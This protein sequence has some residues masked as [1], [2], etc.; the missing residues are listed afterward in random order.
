M[1]NRKWKTGKPDSVWKTCQRLGRQG[2]RGIG[3]WKN[4]EIEK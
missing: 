2:N 4:G 3:K 1:E